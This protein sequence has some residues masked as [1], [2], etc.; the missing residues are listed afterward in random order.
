M[1]DRAVSSGTQDLTGPER[2]PADRR[3]RD[4]TERRWKEML[5]LTDDEQGD[6]MSFLATVRG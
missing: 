1:G 3:V 2:N 4:V 5:G 6:H